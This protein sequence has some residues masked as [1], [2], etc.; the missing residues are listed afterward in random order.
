MHGLFILSILKKVFSPNNINKIEE[1]TMKTVIGIDNGTQSTKVIFYDY[2]N[3]TIAAE[4][5][6]PHS[7]ISKEDGTREQDASQWIGALDSC[8]AQIPQ[9]VKN[10]ALAIGVS[11]QQHGCVPLGKDGTVLTPVKLWCDTST[12]TECDEITDSFGGRDALIQ[13][14][15]NPMLPG[16]TASKILYLK[17]HHQSLY[18]KVAYILLP[19]DYINYYLTGEIAMEYGDASGTGLLDIRKRT[20]HKGVIECIDS[21]LIDKLPPLRESNE[22]LGTILPEIAKKYGLPE[23]IPLAMG[24]GDNMMGAIGTGSLEPG[25]ITVSLGTSGTLFATTDQPFIDDKG[26]IAAFCSSSGSWLPLY[27]TMNCTVASELTRNL[28]DL[29]VKEFDSLA[30]SAQP[31][32]DGITM[33]PYFNGERS[34]NLPSETGKIFGMRQ[35]NMS[36][37]NIAR[38]AMEGATFGLRRGLD[39]FVSLGYKPK[40]LR[41]I[42]GGANSP[43][44]R[45]MIANIFNLPV[46]VP[47]S[48]EAPAMG[49]ALQGLALISSDT[50]EALSSKHIALNQE[51]TVYPQKEVVTQYQEVYK[52][53]TELVETIISHNNQEG[54]V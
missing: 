12:G 13:K 45:Q 24:G 51:A 36:Q 53:Y 43:L 54:G 44:W 16:Y 27:C 37:K 50:V 8:F 42:G 26:E 5:S 7:L 32:A 9:E 11:G 46:V 20:W 25:D 2:E 18:K 30:E 39:S 48:K 49:A 19:H 41:L 10:S 1:T 6:A 38:A 23:G 4:S 34:P 28:F 40:N 52:R 31:G 35:D 29:G 47:Q 21:G 15:G 17:K 33:V 3:K 22:I 14:V